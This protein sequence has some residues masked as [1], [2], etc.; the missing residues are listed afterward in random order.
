MI[1][2]G[3]FRRSC[4]IQMSYVILDMESVPLEITDESIW[5]YLS[6]KAMVRTMHPAFSKVIVVGIKGLTL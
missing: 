5:I 1:M 4:L 3:L 6:E 2:V